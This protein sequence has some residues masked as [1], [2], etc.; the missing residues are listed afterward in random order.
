MSSLRELLSGPRY[1]V[2]PAKATE[3][4]VAEWVPTGMTVAVTASPVKGRA[5]IARRSG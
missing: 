2:I 3:Q 1:E 4:A 5:A